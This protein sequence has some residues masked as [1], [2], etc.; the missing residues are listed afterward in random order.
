M[1]PRPPVFFI[2]LLFG[3]VC[4]WI[5][6]APAWAVQQHGGAEGLV[7][8]E[9]GHIL[10]VTGMVYLLFRIHRL[11]AH[12]EPGWLQFKLFLWLIILWNAL[13][14]T[15]HWLQEIVDPARFVT[16]N[17]QILGYRIASPADLLFY[18]SRLD[19]LFLVPALVFLLLALNKWWRSA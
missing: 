18:L 19:H 10:F 7:S 2:F 17:D 16:A 9:I 1:L 3:L 15:G 11:P 14:F 5:W 13:T 6:T 4:T 8:H 12:R